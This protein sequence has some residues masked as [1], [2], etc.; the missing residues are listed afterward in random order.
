MF[1]SHLL[2]SSPPSLAPSLPPPFS[3]LP[4]LIG[5]LPVDTGLYG[6]DIPSS[7]LFSVQWSGN[8]TE[9]LDCSNSTSG[10][11]ECTYHSAG[12]ICQGQQHDISTLM[13][14]YNIHTYMKY[15]Y[16]LYTKHLYMYV[17]AYVI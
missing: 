4:P 10:S 5:A 6:D 2:P 13:Y 9:I 11:E 1:S 3:S 16:P 14:M 12:V 8:E 17:G 15:V 7:P